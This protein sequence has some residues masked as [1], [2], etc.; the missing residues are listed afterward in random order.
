MP[1]P[2]FIKTIV[3]TSVLSFLSFLIILLRL[4]NFAFTGIIK[5]P[6]VRFFY[7]G[8]YSIIIVI[9]SLFTGGAIFIFS[10]LI[11]ALIFSMFLESYQEQISKLKE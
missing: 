11:S 8:L 4:P 2:S 3:I 6:S 10:S 1:I 9:A 5:Y 7:D